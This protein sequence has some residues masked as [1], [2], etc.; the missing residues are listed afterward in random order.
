MRSCLL[1]PLTQDLDALQIFYHPLLR[2][3]EL[4]LSLPDLMSRCV[5][6]PDPSANSRSTGRAWLGVQV[7]GQKTDVVLQNAR[8]MEEH[9]HFSFELGDVEVQ[10]VTLI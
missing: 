3:N 8:V 6:L 9:F 1:T 4:R 7:F 10:I 2:H 5:V